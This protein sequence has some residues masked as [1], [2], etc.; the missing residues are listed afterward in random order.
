[1]TSDRQG[2]SALTL[3]V[4]IRAARLHPPARLELAEIVVV[5]LRGRP[6]DTGSEREGGHAPPWQGLDRVAGR[7]E[8]VGVLAIAERPQD[9]GPRP[10]GRQRRQAGGFELEPGL[11][12]G[13]GDVEPVV[14]GLEQAGDVSIARGLPDIRASG[15]GS[16]ELE[17]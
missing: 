15:A 12:A 3:K 8:R 14:V 13:A 17:S 11:V 10:A 1:M 16:A 6:G 9:V 5:S 7:R 2:E 4:E